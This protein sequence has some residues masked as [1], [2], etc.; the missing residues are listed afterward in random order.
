MCR[1]SGLVIVGKLAHSLNARELDLSRNYYSDL[2]RVCKQWIDMCWHIRQTSTHLLDNITANS[3]DELIQI[4]KLFC[5]IAAGAWACDRYMWWYWYVCL[6][7]SKLDTVGEN[8]NIRS[9]WCWRH[10]GWTN[11]PFPVS[12]IVESN[13]TLPRLSLHFRGCDHG[14]EI[15][16]AVQT[17]LIDLSDF[18]QRCE[19]TNF[20]YVH[21][22]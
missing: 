22:L 1:G 13:S 8:D 7:I 9:A 15:K 6:M 20:I 11:E 10:R 18:T 14:S 2:C 17:S 5:T 19:S 21:N 3:V 16:P 4:G 12:M